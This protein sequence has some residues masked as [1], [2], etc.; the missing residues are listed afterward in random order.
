VRLTTTDTP[1]SQEAFAEYCAYVEKLERVV[2]RQQ[3]VLVDVGGTL[4]H[5]TH[6]GIESMLAEVSKVIEE[7]RKAEQ[8]A[9]EG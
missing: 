8:Q 5:L 2:R 3:D 6:I 9:E 1:R 7:Q 4:R